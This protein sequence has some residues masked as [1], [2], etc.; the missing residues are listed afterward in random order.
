MTLLVFAAAVAAALS[1]ALLPVN[2]AVF[3]PLGRPDPPGEWPRV[4]V[5]IPARNEER[6]L[7]RTLAA[8][9]RSDY[10]RLEVIV[11]D[12]RSTDRTGEIARRFEERDP[13]F[14]AICG[15]EPPDGWL[16]KPHALHEGALAATGEWLLFAD[17]DVVYGPDVIRRAVAAALGGRVALLCLLPRFETRGFWE[18]VIMPNV[19]ALLYLGPGFVT[20]IER[21]KAFAGGSGSGNLVERSG[22][23][24]SGGHAAIRGAVIDDLGLAVSMKRAG[25]RTRAFTAYD[26][27][28]VRMY[29]GLRE[30]VVGFSKNVAYLGPPAAALLLP[31]A[32]FLLAMAPWVAL[33]TPALRPLA[34]GTIAATILGRVVVARVTRM[35]AWSALFHPAMIAVWTGIAMRSWCER[36]VRRRLTWRGRTT[37]APG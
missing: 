9:A 6:D 15:A 17:A 4:S 37:A 35:P 16:G 29:R 2:L 10:P 19:Y 8:H 34:L 11:V 36:I 20:Q 33:A 5:V 13:R 14:R 7:E 25:R 12:D 31:L 32:V 23:E 24:G 22:Y 21:V 27:V 3:R 30:T 26:E 28:R 18:A 1:L